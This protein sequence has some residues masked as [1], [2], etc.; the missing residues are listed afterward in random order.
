[1][2]EAF[3]DCNIWSVNLTRQPYIEHNY[4]LVENIY[5]YNSLSSGIT[6]FNFECAQIPEFEISDIHLL[7]GIDYELINKYQIPILCKNDTFWK[8]DLKNYEDSKLQSTNI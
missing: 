6:N 2:S 7:D 1:M 4:F 3:L 5:Y 8:I